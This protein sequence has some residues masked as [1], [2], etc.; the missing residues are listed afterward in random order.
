M[1]E[2]YASWVTLR[3]QWDRYR[4][5][6]AEARLL[7]FKT[8]WS[9]FQ[10]TSQTAPEQGE[11]ELCILYFE[12]TLSEFQ[13]P[14]QTDT[15]Q[16]EAELHILDFKITWSDSKTQLLPSEV[17]LNYIYTTLKKHHLP[18][19]GPKQLCALAHLGCTRAA[20]TS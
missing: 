19:V 10:K 3:P 17:K 14:S 13:K 6:E 4:Q 9:E 20:G 5:G 7:N 15:E 16:G 18:R 8:T 11:A 12:T 1:S 2:K